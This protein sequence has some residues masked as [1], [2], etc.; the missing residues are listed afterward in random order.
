MAMKKLS[1]LVNVIPIL[2]KG[3]S[4]TKM[5]IQEIKMHF[6]EQLLEF[7]I[8]IFKGQDHHHQSNFG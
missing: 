4:Y 2:A 3:D 7:R 5:E 6:S 8:E 1:Q